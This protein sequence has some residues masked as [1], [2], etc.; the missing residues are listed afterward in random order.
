M[1]VTRRLLPA[2]EARMTELFDTRL[3]PDDHAMD[4]DELATAMQQADVLVP[5]VTDR[6]DAALIAEA[7]AQ[8]G[9]IASFGAGTDHIDLHACR[10]RKIMV[11]IGRAHV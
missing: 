7:G 6:I 11:K 3:N 10:M 9:L 2:T 5:T 8:L 1:I 4:R